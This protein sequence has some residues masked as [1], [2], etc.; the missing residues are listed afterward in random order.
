MH[1]KLPSFAEFRTCRV[2]LIST[3]IMSFAIMLGAEAS[4]Q[5][6]NTPNASCGVYKSCFAKYCPCK[7]PNEYFV[8]YGKKYCEAF[9]TSGNF[10]ND[11]ARWR[12]RTLTC[13]QERIVPKLDISESP[14]CNCAEMRLF[15]FETHVACYTQSNSSICDLGLSDLNEIRRIIDLSDLLSIDGLR[16]TKAVVEICK[17]AA[18]DSGR[19]ALW[20]SLSLILPW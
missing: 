18:P 7:G 4:A 13:L 6:L 20:E 15:A 17:A 16:Q 10:S 5:C 8:K 2:V 19:R 14:S 1:K 3:L 12:D 11:G 9:L